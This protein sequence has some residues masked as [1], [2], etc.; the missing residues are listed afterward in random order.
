MKKI[1]I[2]LCFGLSLSGCVAN[3]PPALKQAGA[4]FQD[5]Y[6]RIV[7]D[8]LANKG[9]IPGKKIVVYEFQDLS[10]RV[11]PE[12]RLVAERLTTR[13]VQTGEFEVIERNRLETVLK[14]LKLSASGAVDENT[15]MRAG[16][17]LGAAAVVTGTLAQMS[18]GFEVN[19]RVIDAENGKILAGAT[20]A[21]LENSL[22]VKKTGSQPHIYALQASVSQSANRPTPVSTSQLPR[23]PKGWE[24]WEGWNNSYGSFSLA[25]G[26]LLYSLDTRQ[27]DHAWADAPKDGYYPG[28][29]LARPIRGD[30]WTIELKANYTMPDA[31]GRW[32]STCVWI[33][34]K[35]IRPS[36]INAEENLGVCFFR[37]ADQAGYGKNSECVQVN[38]QSGGKLLKTA[39]VPGD[40]KYLRFK[41]DWTRFRLAYSDDG[42]N[43]KDLLDLQAPESLQGEAQKLVFGGQ[44]FGHPAGSYAEYEDI[45]I[46]GK[47]ELF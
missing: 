26:R 32:F 20:A 12:G 30:K 13:L 28:L 4:L 11:T 46:N 39:T 44:S 29:L 2:L 41:R 3:R 35:G 1:F 14:E 37:R 17:I 5:P 22:N 7:K 24:I 25:G 42:K 6:D 18:S 31:G 27:H 21:I 16:K 40:H 45:R 23:S 15:A 10:G 38:Y 47:K 8:F 36:L 43:Y 33:G 9:N 19:A 34:K